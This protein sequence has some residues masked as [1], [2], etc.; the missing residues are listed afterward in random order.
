MCEYC[1]TKQ[2]NLIVNCCGFSVNID[3]MLKELSILHNK[4]DDY[5]KDVFTEINFCP[6]CGR[7]L[8]ELEPLTLDELRHG[9]PTNIRRTKETKMIYIKVFNEDES[10]PLFAK[11]KF[12]K[13]GEKIKSEQTALQVISAMLPQFAFIAA[14]YISKEEYDQECDDEDEMELNN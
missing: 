11:F 10:Y 1:I 12:D 7:P 9:L 3:A 14:E 4:I 8:S 5:D 6:F 2:T 13:D